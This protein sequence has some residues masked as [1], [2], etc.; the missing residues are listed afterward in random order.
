ML[1]C[2]HVATGDIQ[3]LPLLCPPLRSPS[4]GGLPPSCPWPRAHLACPRPRELLVRAPAPTPRVCVQV[5]RWAAE[6]GFGVPPPSRAKAP[7]ASAPPPFLALSPHI[8]AQLGWP[9]INGAQLGWPS[10]N[11]AS[12]VPS[13]PSFLCPLYP[14]LWANHDSH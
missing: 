2:Q 6:T 13:T 12:H 9:S 7:T 8:G 10:I 3:R 1:P 14:Q 5:T 11:P 4:C